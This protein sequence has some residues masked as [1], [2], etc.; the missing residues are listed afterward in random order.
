MIRSE[1]MNVDSLS[2]WLRIKVILYLIDSEGYTLMNMRWN[3]VVVVVSNSRAI[4]GRI[5]FD[6]VFGGGIFEA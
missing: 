3:E 1:T 5:R 4:G 6:G 2:A